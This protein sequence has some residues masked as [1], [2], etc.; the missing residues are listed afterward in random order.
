MLEA[1]V[2]VTVPDEEL[3]GLAKGGDRAALEELF[4]RHSP[5]CFRVACRLLGNEHDARDALQDGMIKAMTHLKDFDGRSGFRTW[6]LRIVTNAAFDAGRKRKRRPMLQLGTAES[7]GYEPSEED[8]P[9]LALRRKD[10]EAKLAGALDKLPAENR[11][12]FILFAEG[13]CSY[14]EIAAIQN[15]PTGTVM[16]RIF[17]ARRKLQAYL[18]GVDGL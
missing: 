4:R 1:A 13:G 5:V 17:Y 12:A 9:T 6:L 18:E 14:K 15:T 3:V 7:G 11:T 10:L 8:D 2:G 16:S